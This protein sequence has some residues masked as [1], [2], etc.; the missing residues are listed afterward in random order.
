M[1]G[2][3]MGLFD[4]GGG[5]GIFSLFYQTNDGDGSGNNNNEGTSGGARKFPQLY[6]FLGLSVVF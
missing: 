3:T 4:S 1:A 5:S 2:A 6:R